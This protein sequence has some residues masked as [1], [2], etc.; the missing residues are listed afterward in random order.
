VAALAP[1]PDGKLVVGGGFTSVNGAARRAIVRLNPDGRADPTFNPGAGPDGVVYA[2]A[3]QPDG[4]VILAG[5]FNNVG[6]TP[7]DRLARLFGDHPPPLAPRLS[8]AMVAGNQTGISFVSEPGRTFTLELSDSLFPPQW[9]L[10]SSCLGD[11]S[12]K[13]LFDTNVPPQQRFYRV[14]VE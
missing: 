7:R 1:Q 5:D 10:G 11:G 4:N 9:I 2:L 8:I 6:G 12:P 3:L 14:H 13:T